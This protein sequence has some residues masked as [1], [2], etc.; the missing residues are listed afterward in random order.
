M[1]ISSCMGEGEV[2][3]VRYIRERGREGDVIKGDM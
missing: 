1:C 3:K 2:E